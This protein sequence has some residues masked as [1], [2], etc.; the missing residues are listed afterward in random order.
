MDK[1]SEATHIPVF[2]PTSTFIVLWD[3]FQI[4]II[5]LIL[6]WLPYK[7]SFN[8]NYMADLLGLESGHS[9]IETIFIA[10]LGVD[11]II[12]CNLAFI[13]KGLIIR[14]RS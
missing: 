8:T 3:L 13:K 6:L 5:L 1:I 12:G 11:V 2:E 14:K 10:I 9:I 4:T 7:I